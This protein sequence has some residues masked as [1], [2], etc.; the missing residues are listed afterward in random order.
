MMMAAAAATTTEL[1]RYGDE[2]TGTSPAPYLESVEDNTPKRSSIFSRSSDVFFPPLLRI[3]AEYNSSRRPLKRCSRRNLSGLLLRR[4]PK[5]APYT[6]DE[7]SSDNKSRAYFRSLLT[8]TYDDNA[9]KRP[10]PY[11]CFSKLLDQR[12]IDWFVNNTDNSEDLT[13]EDCSTISSPPLLRKSGSRNLPFDGQSQST[14]VDEYELTSEDGSSSLLHSASTTTDGRN[15]EI[16]RELLRSPYKF[17]RGLFRD[18][19]MPSNAASTMGRVKS[20]PVLKVA[21]DELSTVVVVANISP[22]TT[23]N[24]PAAIASFPL[25]SSCGDSSSS[26]LLELE[27]ST[28][29]VANALRQLRQRLCGY[30]QPLFSDEY[31]IASILD[32]CRA[33]FPNEFILMLTKKLDIRNLKI[34]RRPARNATS[35]ALDC[36]AYVSGTVVSASCAAPV[37]AVADNGPTDLADRIVRQLKALEPNSRNRASLAVVHFAAAQQQAA[38]QHN[39]AA[40][41]AQQQHCDQQIQTANQY[42][43]NTSSE[44]T[45]TIS[46]SPSIAVATLSYDKKALDFGTLGASYV[47]V[48]TRRPRTGRFKLVFRSTDTARGGGCLAGRV[49]LSERGEGALVLVANK[50]FGLLM[51]DDAVAELLSLT[52]SPCEAE[53]TGDRALNT[54]IAIVVDL[55]AA[56]AAAAAAAAAGGGGGAIAPGATPTAPTA[57]SSKIAVAAAWVVRCS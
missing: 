10:T 3:A 54:P 33:V 29:D 26:S 38:A 24:T 41:A 18:Y 6:T 1:Y 28:V 14:T 46:T 27:T 34:C 7:T 40:V 37:M 43:I 13:E 4:S 8:T 15:T 48:F 44:Q 25:S 53:A 16:L 2:T 23:H 22:T 21:E 12:P 45:T 35:F 50:E 11:I 31:A 17:Q 19:K 49:P 51:P 20:T 32:R 55:L 36:A 56:G 57:S 42:N 39:A 30:R 47:A 5:W 9:T 52:V